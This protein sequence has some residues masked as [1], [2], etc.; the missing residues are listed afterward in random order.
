MMKS[1]IQSLID[2][3]EDGKPVDLERTSRLLVLDMAREGER[4]AK[5]AAKLFVMTEDSAK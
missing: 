4:F 5:E 1:R 2:D 3:I